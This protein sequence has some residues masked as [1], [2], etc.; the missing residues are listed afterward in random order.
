MYSQ[1]N[2][3]VACVFQHPSPR[4]FVFS[5]NLQISDYSNNFTW[6]RLKGSSKEKKSYIG[7][8]LLNN[9]KNMK[10]DWF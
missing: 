10:T 8:L 3:C 6:P 4:S 7:D 2:Q 9:L 1:L 5:R